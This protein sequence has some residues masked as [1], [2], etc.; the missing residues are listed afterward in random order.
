MVVNS[1]WAELYSDLSDRSIRSLHI[2]SEPSGGSVT[3]FEH[4]R[5]SVAHDVI[6]GDGG[7]LYVLG[8]LSIGGPW[9]ELSQVTVHSDGKLHVG[10][11][12]TLQA[13][14]GEVT[15]ADEGVLSIDGL[16]MANRV[17]C[18]GRS[19]LTSSPGSVD[20]STINGDLKLAESASLEVDAIDAGVDK[21]EVDNLWFAGS[22]GLKI[23]ISGRSRFRAGTYTLISASSAV[24]G[25]FSHVTDL[26]AYVS[27][28]PGGDGLIYGGGRVTLTLD[29]DLH[30]GDGNLDG[31]TD[32]SDRIIWNENNF[33]EG[34]TFQTGDYNGD[35]ATDVSD[36]ILWNQYNFTE[37]TTQGTLAP[38]PEPASTTL[39]LLAL[40]ATPLR[41]RRGAKAYHTAVGLR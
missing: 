25:A 22:N 2:A 34:T 3:I 15:V 1:G 6:V 38:V 33:T 8:G 16:V 19:S 5:L 40:V 32:V 36:R 13:A 10:R 21:L 37:A 35:G 11:G 26:N 28:G 18:Q 17:I 31:A 23:A 9:R 14:R 30:P 20:V 24:S 29:M 4:G 12:S 41:R 7:T 27:R 39:I